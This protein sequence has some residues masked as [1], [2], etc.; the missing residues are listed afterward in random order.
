MTLGA[1]LLLAAL[2][3]GCT[4][5]NDAPSKPSPSVQA[6]YV[7]QVNALCGKL[8]TQVLAFD[9]GNVVS[10]EEFLTKHEKLVAAIQ[11]FDAEVES[12]RVTAADRKAAD[13]F[14]AYRRFSDAAD[15]PVFAAAQTGDQER[16]EAA[17]D[18][19]L[20]T[21]HGGVTEIDRMHKVGIQCNAR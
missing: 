17:N 7:T 5:S 16:F 9:I 1:A 19:Y 4:D 8:L 6:D 11:D 2:V 3:T 14:D 15:A 21:V 10:T 18:Q 13:A 12:I 20:E